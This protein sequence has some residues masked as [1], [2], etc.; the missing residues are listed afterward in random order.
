MHT[1]KQINWSHAETKRDEKQKG[2]MQRITI[3]EIEI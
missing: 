1:Y 3:K 2:S